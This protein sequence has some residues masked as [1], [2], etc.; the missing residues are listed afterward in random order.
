MCK[1]SLKVGF[2][3]IELLVVIAI[4]GI[5]AAILLPALARAREAARRASC[6]NNLKQWG[7]IFKMYSSE[8]KGKY[9]PIELEMDPNETQVLEAVDKSSLATAP[10]YSAIYPEYMTD[11]SILL[12]PSDPDQTVD[13]LKWD[14][15]EW[16]FNKG[17]HQIY[18]RR[19][20]GVS[21][22]YLGWVLDRCADEAY[23]AESIEPIMLLLAQ[24]GDYEDSQ[25][26]EAPSQ[27]AKSILTMMGNALL[28]LTKL[29]SAP[30]YVKAH[31]VVDANL[32]LSI[33]EGGAG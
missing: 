4:I 27:V 1:K 29:D 31:R 20:T 33:I 10:M 23:P 8:S 18:N 16:L 19:L 5:L 32:D 17:T 6:Q 14:S 11:P 12:C 3:L 9:P 2:T 7:L 21:Y 30:L 24:F 15:G 22:N 25:G 26:E 13:D 28:E